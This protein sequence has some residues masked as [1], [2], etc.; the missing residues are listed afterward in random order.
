MS[1]LCERFRALN[2]TAQMRAAHTALVARAGQP[3]GGGGA[4]VNPG[5][6]YT[7]GVTFAAALAANG[8][9]A[10]FEMTRSAV[11]ETAA[12]ILWRVGVDVARLTMRMENVTPPGAG[13]NIYLRFVIANGN[14]AIA[15]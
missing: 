2:L 14:A 4:L 7:L 5:T 8:T 10:D 6:E 15:V 9:N 11:M 1:G 3:P 13:G 12:D